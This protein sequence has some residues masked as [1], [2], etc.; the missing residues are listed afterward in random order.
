M[1]SVCYLTSWC[2]NKNILQTELMFLYQRG[3]DYLITFKDYFFY[4]PLL[5]PGT[6]VKYGETTVFKGVTKEEYEIIKESSQKKE[7]KVS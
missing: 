3:V 4:T 6:L 5:N 2:Y 1:K 7:E